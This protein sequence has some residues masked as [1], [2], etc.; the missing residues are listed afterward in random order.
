M[1]D[2]IQFY[3]DAFVA[4]F[5]RKTIL[6]NSQ[7]RHCMNRVGFMVDKDDE[8]ANVL[9]MM[10]DYEDDLR[11]IPT[12]TPRDQLDYAWNEPGAP[13]RSGDY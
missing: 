5:G 4:Q 1:N 2:L 7:I 6:T 13:F 12:D 3:R 9:D 10:D 8:A 11:S